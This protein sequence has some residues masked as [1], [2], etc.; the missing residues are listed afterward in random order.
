MRLSDGRWAERYGHGSENL[1][2]GLDHQARP[3]ELA[4][5]LTRLPPGHPSADLE[6][7]ADDDPD[8]GDLN[9]D[10]VEPD[11]LGPE[12]V[13]PDD[14][15]YDD[16]DPEDF[17]PDDGSDDVRPDDAEN[18]AAAGDIRPGRSGHTPTWGELD[19]PARSL[20]RPWFGAGGATDP[21]FAADLT[22]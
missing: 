11:D 2:A 15:E 16:L 5:R 14:L 19:E 13:D 22:E 4:G 10:E 12:G 21:W 1:H 6:G 8:P 7:E 3:D 9:P 18:R 17:A 20:Y